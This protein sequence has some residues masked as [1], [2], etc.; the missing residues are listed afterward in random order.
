LEKAR[1]ERDAKNRYLNPNKQEKK[2]LTAEEKEAQHKNLMTRGAT[3]PPE[4]ERNIRFNQLMG[5][6]SKNDFSPKASG[7]RHPALGCTFKSV[8]LIQGGSS[9]AK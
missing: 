2:N 3:K 4:H 7:N 5:T 9:A 8:F 6:S 1:F